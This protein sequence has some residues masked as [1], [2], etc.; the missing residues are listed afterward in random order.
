MTEVS[1]IL[2]IRIDQLVVGMY[3]HDLNCPWFDHPFAR[4]RFL[5]RSEQTLAEIRRLGVQELFIDASKGHS[6]T[7][8]LGATLREEEIDAR[9]LEIA[10]EADAEPQRAALA[11]EMESAR[12]LHAQAGSIVRGLMQDVC[13]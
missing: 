8:P 1:S 9:L 3:V 12:K 7:P 4:N 2:R 5:V 6:G 13:Q 10:V 11:Q